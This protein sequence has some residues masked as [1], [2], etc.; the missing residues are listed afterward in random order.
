MYTGWFWRR[1]REKYTSVADWKLSD[2]V[3]GAAYSEP[4]ARRMEIARDRCM[5][6]AGIGLALPC[7]KA[8]EA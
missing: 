1:G 6:Q 7:P 5:E 3:W 8:S 2:V 4:V